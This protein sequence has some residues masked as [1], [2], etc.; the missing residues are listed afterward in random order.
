MP[1]PDEF[2]L[3]LELE[4]LLF[5]IGAGQVDPADNSDHKIMLFGQL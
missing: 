4:K 3:L 1:H 2:W 5:A